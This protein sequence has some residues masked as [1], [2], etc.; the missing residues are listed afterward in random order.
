MSDLC[1]YLKKVHKLVA[2]E[3]ERIRADSQRRKYRELGSDG[4]LSVGDYV[5]VKKEPEKGVS[6]RFQNKTFDQV[7]QVVE[8]HGLGQD[9]R[10]YTLSDL[11]GNRDSLGFSQPVHLDRLIPIEM[12]P[13]QQPSSDQRT[14]LSVE[15]NGQPGRPATIVSQTIDGKVYLKY[16][17]ED[18]EHCVDLSKLRYH[19]L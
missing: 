15:R 9:A 3:H 17:D 14:R 13:L 2:T 12:L 19:W 6:A 4:Y 1:N 10:A 11:V 16:D 18:T 8:C 7:F 5:L